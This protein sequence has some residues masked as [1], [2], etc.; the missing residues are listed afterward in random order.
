MTFFLGCSFTLNLIR[1]TSPLM[2]LFHIQVAYQIIDISSKQYSIY[3]IQSARNRPIINRPKDNPKPCLVAAASEGVPVAPATE[4]E[5]VLAGA[6][7]VGR[8]A[9]VAA[10]VVA[11]AVVVALARAVVDTAIVEEIPVGTVVAFA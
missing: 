3:T 7:V 5:V 8:G 9:R 1:E 10:E 11:T 6:F 2:I 4:A